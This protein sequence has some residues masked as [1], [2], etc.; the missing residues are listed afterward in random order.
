MNVTKWNDNQ[1]YLLKKKRKVSIF[2][3]FRILSLSIALHRSPFTVVVEII[4]DD[5]SCDMIIIIDDNGNNVNGAIVVVVVVA[6]IMANDDSN[7]I[8]Q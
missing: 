5:N 3:I 1:N 8:L 6:R 2:I 4:S 7:Q